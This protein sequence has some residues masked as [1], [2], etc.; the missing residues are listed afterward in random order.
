MLLGVVAWAVTGSILTLV[1]AALGPVLALAAL[2]D[3]AISRRRDN[4]RAQRQAV[5]SCERLEQ[6]IRGRLRTECERIGQLPVLRAD[7]ELTP[8][9]LWSTTTSPIWVHLGFGAIPSGVE[10]ERGELQ[11]VERVVEVEQALAARLEVLSDAPV[12]ADLTAGLTVHGPRLAADAV[13]RWAVLSTLAHLPLATEIEYPRDEVW[14]VSLPHRTR[15][16]AHWVVMAPD[17]APIRIVTS[18]LGGPAVPGIATSLHLA[19]TAELSADGQPP[20]PLAPALTDIRRALALA[21]RFREAAAARGGTELPERVDLEELLATARGDRSG[22]RTPI[23]H[24][25]MAPVILDLVADGPHLLVAGMTGAGKS[26][27]MESVV[28]GLASRYPSTELCFALLDFKG[29]AAFARLAALAHVAGLVTDLDGDDVA[30]AVSGLRAELRARE[31]CLRENRVSA[32]E[33][34]PAGL[35]PRLVVVVDEF[36]VLTAQDTEAHEVF[37]DLASRGRSLGIHLV[38]G[39]QRPAA[40]MRDGILANAGLRLSLRVNNRADSVALTGS[41]LAAELPV[42]VPGRAILLAGDLAP[43]PVQLAIATEAFV[44]RV[45]AEPGERARAVWAPAL[46]AVLTGGELPVGSIG[47]GERRE[48]QRLEVLSYE[49]R[50]DG[51]VLVVGSR[52]AGKSSALAAIAT[53][54]GCRVL[55]ADRDTAELWSLLEA[56]ERTEVAPGPLLLLIDDLDLHLA[57]DPERRAELLRKLAGVGRQ[58]ARDGG[59]VLAS[60]SRGQTALGPLHACFDRLLLLGLPGR[61]DHVLAGGDGRQWRIGRRPG[62]AVWMGRE[63][64]LVLATPVSP[65]RVALDRIRLI[66]LPGAV[67]VSRDPDALAALLRSRGVSTAEPTRTAAQPG[68]AV[69]GF[70]DPVLIARAE[71][72]AE[73][74]ELIQTAL[75]AGRIVIADG[76]AATVARLL[77]R[78]APPPPLGT[79]RGEAWLVEAGRARRVLVDE[80]G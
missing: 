4:R 29:G 40:V 57:D 41:S 31:F 65:T 79:R 74:W 67:V 56:V 33:Q 32:I 21:G 8:A 80:L 24:D 51:G 27:A 7:G 12:V 63:V 11:P 46:P 77:P 52:G 28:L 2:A 72:W 47:L 6:R 18:P 9:R 38:L 61:D 5:A 42:G 68:G 75:S 44:S 59:A 48:E 36:A 50:A 17:R 1:F 78:L 54:S 64:Q 73:H 60:A 69:I 66:E 35:L 76:D 14:A 19:P 45:A 10:L 15:P 39:T 58:L 26:A 34:L 62:S 16:G 53:A 43:R 49:P 71:Q 20:V 23:G 25:G 37:A 13:A 55:A 3:G 30:R 22:L 70:T